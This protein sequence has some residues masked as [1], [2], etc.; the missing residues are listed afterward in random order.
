M[1]RP[2]YF[3]ATLPT[4]QFGAEPPMSRESFL[5]QAG[6]FV[7]GEEL[8]VLDGLALSPDPSE[9]QAS[10]SGLIRRY[11]AWASTLRVELGRLRAG[12]AGRAF[13]AAVL[14]TLPRDDGAVTAARA[15][16]AASSPLEGE[17]ELEGRRWAF[18][19]GLCPIQLFEFDGLCAWELKLLVLERLSLLTAERGEAGYRTIYSAI[20]SAH[21]GRQ[22]GVHTSS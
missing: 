8:A 6:R 2:Y 21:A 4:L 17:L 22:G 9:A 5:A 15:A 7:Q 11:A 1:S 10:P 20:L 16:F 13:D 19:D 12:R 14:G 18:I 3:A